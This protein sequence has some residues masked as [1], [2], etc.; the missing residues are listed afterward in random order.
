MLIGDVLDAT[1]V[2]SA[3]QGADYVFHLAALA[4]L[5]AARNLPLDSARINVLG[6]LNVLDACREFHVERF[7]FA[8]TIYVYSREGGFYRCSK[9]ACEAYIEEYQ[10]CYNQDYTVLRYGSLYGPRADDSN[11]LLRLLKQ[12]TE[13]SRISYIGSPEDTR[14]YI[15]VE[16]AAKLSV[17]ALAPD[18]A[19]QSLII[20][21]PYPM[22]ASDLFAMFSE[23]V[24]RKLEIE[25]VSEHSASNGH[26]QITPYSYSPKPGRKVFS[27]CYVDMGQGLLQLLEQIHGPVPA[28]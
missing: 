21:G 27:T 11:G 23:I 14:E 4:D 19:N 28:Q 7:V 18:F 16:D 13:Q 20:T 12:A 25:Y 2:R 1:T 17:D 26:Y 8:S 22:R 10:R 6:T 15:H 5:N 3:I 9:Q 24:G